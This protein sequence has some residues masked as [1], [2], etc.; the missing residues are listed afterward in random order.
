MDMKDSM[1]LT[2]ALALLASCSTT[3]LPASLHSES[4]ENPWA[5]VGA[6]D[7]TVGGSTG[8]AFYGAE[9]EAEG[10]PGTD[11]QGE[12]GT[13]TTT[14]TPR[15]GGALKVNRF[16]TDDFSLGL[17]YEHRNFEADPVSPLS[18]TLVSEPF[19]TNHFLLSA[20]YWGAPTGKQRRWRPFSGI[21]IGYVPEVDFGTVDVVYDGL[22][23]EQITIVGSDYWTAAVV[24]GAS[25]MMKE[26]L[27]FD[28]GAFYEWAVTPG[29]DTLTLTTLG[30]GQVETEVWASGLILFAGL[31][32]YF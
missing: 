21:D 32:W 2:A 28:V 26:G 27:A 15:Y 23:D 10:V 17:V 16:I 14:L 8:W 31:S 30:G 24:A 4:M 11:L 5:D 19:A 20:R 25:Y 29:E 18:A 13:D 9:V 6:G 22:P 12:S 3:K 7:W 1:I